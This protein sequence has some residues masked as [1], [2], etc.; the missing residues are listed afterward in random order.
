V[1]VVGICL[2]DFWEES[3]K[4]LKNF[5]KNR[6]ANEEDTEDILHDVLLKLISNIDKL[7]DDQKVHAWIYKI[8]RNAII[9]YY[10]RNHKSLDLESVPEELPLVLDE[11]LTSNKEIA[12]CLKNMV[13]KLPEKYKQAIQITVFENHTQKEYSEIAGISLSGA[14][15][16]VQRARCFL[17][18][19]VFGCC[20]L[21]FDRLGNIIDYKK[22]SA[23]C[24]YC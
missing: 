12:Y 4:P 5:I 19:M 18:E 6:V 20:S 22:R 1:I 15:S 8:T 2:V 11:D 14:K 13:D 24:K 3:K 10:R 17:K 23:D 21:E 16:R 9:D 7:M